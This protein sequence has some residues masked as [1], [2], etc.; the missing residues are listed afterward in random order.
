[1]PEKHPPKAVT[2]SKKDLLTDPWK[3]LRERPGVKILDVA[4]R[5]SRER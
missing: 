2:D 4:R 1:L 5:N 3:N